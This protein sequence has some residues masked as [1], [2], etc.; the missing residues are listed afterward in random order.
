MIEFLATPNIF[1][2]SG[3]LRKEVGFNE[4]TISIVLIYLL[5]VG[6]RRR[7]YLV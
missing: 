2:F 3:Q 7:L 5:R 1:P 4:E 6:G